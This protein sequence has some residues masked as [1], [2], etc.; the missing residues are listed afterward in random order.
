MKTLLSSYLSYVSSGRL[1]SDI[2][3]MIARDFIFL[4]QHAE[5]SKVNGVAGE[6]GASNISC[7]NPP[8]SLNTVINGN[9]LNQLQANPFKSHHNDQAPTPIISE[10]VSEMS[11]NHANNNSIHPQDENPVLH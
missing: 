6:G 3:V 4:K 10:F 7:M 11:P 9:S 1:R 5:N 2:A 8:S